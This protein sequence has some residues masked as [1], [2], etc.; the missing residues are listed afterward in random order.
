MSSLIPKISIGRDTKKGSHFDLSSMTHT[1]SEIGYVQPTFSK[2]LVPGSNVRIGTRT[3]VRLSP[4]YVPT[5]GQIDVRHY[6]D[7]VPFNTLWFPFDAFVTHTNYT[8]PS[9]ETYVPTAIPYFTMSSLFWN[10]FATFGVSD[11]RWID[12]Q[13]DLVCSVYVIDDETGNYVPVTSQALFNQNNSIFKTDDIEIYPRVIYQID[14]DYNEFTM[15]YCTT[16]ASGKVLYTQHMSGV[17]DWHVVPTPQACDFCYP[18]HYIVDGESTPCLITYNF[19][20]SLKRLRTAFLGLGYSFNPFD[21]ERV[22]PL[23]LLALYKMYWEH[24]GINRTF[25]FFNTNCYKLI[26]YLSD[27]VCTSISGIDLSNPTLPSL[28]AKFICDLPYMTYSC[29][30]DYFSSADTTTNRGAQNV[31]TNLPYNESRYNNQGVFTYDSDSV[32]GSYT[33]DGGYIDSSSHNAASATDSG[34]ARAQKIAMRLLRFVNKNSVI[35]RSITDLLRARYGMTDVHNTTHED[36]I[37]VGSSSCPIEISAVYNN[38]DSGDMPLGSYAGLGVG[39]RRSKMFKFRTDTFGVVITLTAVVPKMGYWQGM[40]RENCDGVNGSLDFYTPEF[41]AIGWQG[42]RYSELVADRMHLFH[43][44]DAPIGT[45]LGLFGYQPFYSH[46]KCG[47]NRCL[48]DIS[49]PHLRDSMLPYTLDRYFPDY[50]N[51]SDAIV[52]EVYQST[53]LPPNDPQTFRSGTQGN[54]NRIFSDTSKTDDHV[55]MQIFFDVKMTAPM[56]SLATSYDTWDEESSDSVDVS[57]E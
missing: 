29:A 51:K 54:T 3:G 50:E 28:F 43:S 44:G 42:L 17:Q 57:H 4:L 45:A 16:D 40:L 22:T 23:A 34:M 26:K 5:M 15:M 1:T 48:G 33:V 7:F 11:T 14:V 10:L 36:V 21:T 20:G 32:D 52:G 12:L 55:I 46:L 37:K 38:T 56:K 49:I 35:G 25:N 30:P 13:N 2:F 24:F 9:G 27:H 53:L 8:L 41:D 39:S 47:H 19:C 18:S 31:G 6:H